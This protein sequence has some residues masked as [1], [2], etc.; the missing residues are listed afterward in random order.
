MEMKIPS[1]LPGEN[2]LQPTAMS[3]GNI[4]DAG[5]GRQ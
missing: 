3:K 4:G 5:P 2:S 1:S